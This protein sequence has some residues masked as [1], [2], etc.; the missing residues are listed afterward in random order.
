MFGQNA[1][2]KKKLVQERWIYGKRQLGEY[3]VFSVIIPEQVDLSMGFLHLH[4]IL[5]FSSLSETLRVACFP[6]GVREAS[7]T[8]S[9][10]WGVYILHT[11]S[12]NR[13]ILY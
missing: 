3:E 4:F 8:A 2:P 13:A 11:S 5:A 1:T 6:V 10:L 9:R 7:P 12:F